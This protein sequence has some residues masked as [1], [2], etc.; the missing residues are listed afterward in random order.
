VTAL[1]RIEDLY[2]RARAVLDAAESEGKASLSLAAIREARGLVETLAKITGELDERS[3]MQVVNVMT[4]PEWVAIR[5]AV[6]EELAAFPE[7]AAAVA[8]R[9]DGLP[10]LEAGGRS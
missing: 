10:A 8:A 6:M 1:E 2:T 9:L 3:T 5:L 4:S 7:A